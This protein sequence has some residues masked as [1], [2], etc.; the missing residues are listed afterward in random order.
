MAETD[1]SL[2]D[3]AVQH[4]GMV[5]KDA[6]ATSRFFSEAWGVRPWVNWEYSSTAEE[7]VLGKPFTIRCWLARLGPTALELIEPVDSPNSIWAQFLEEH[8]EGFHHL[9]YSLPPVDRF[10]EKIRQL[11]A[12]GSR[13]LVHAMMKPLPTRPAGNQ[14]CYLQMQPGG[15][16]VELMSCLPGRKVD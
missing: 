1:F 5:V 16:V 3:L 15:M 6:E 7:M 12:G 14:W 4:V 13:R 8:G 10:T 9:A 2:R 11:E